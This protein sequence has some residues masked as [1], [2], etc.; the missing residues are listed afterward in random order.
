MKAIL[1]ALMMFRSLDQCWV[2]LQGMSSFISELIKENK[3]TFE[4]KRSCDMNAYGMY[5]KTV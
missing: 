1:E 4:N 3:G 2:R 5:G